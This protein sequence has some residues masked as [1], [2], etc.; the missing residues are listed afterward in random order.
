MISLFLERCS[1]SPTISVENIKNY[2]SMFTLNLIICVATMLFAFLGNFLYPYISYNYLNN[3][4][5]SFRWSRNFLCVLALTTICN[6]L[7]SGLACRSIDILYDFRFT[8]MIIVQ[9]VGFVICLLFAFLLGIKYALL[10]H[11]S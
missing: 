3:C 4:Y 9:I 6:Q 1:L 5:Q 7:A 11:T 8:S 2:M 10:N